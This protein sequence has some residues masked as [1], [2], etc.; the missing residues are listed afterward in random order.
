MPRFAV[1]ISQHAMRM[2]IPKYIDES[3][4]VRESGT[5]SFYTVQHSPTSSHHVPSR[6]LCIAP[7]SVLFFSFVSGLA[8]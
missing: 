8:S 4:L 1:K 7:T 6:G 5:P 3:I 2:W